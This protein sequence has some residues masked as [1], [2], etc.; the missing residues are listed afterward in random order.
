[1]T[2]KSTIYDKTFHRFEA[3][4]F[5]N[6]Q[7]DIYTMLDNKYG[8]Q[9]QIILQSTLTNYTTMLAMIISYAYQFKVI[10]SNVKERIFPTKSL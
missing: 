9:I 5:K 1:M 4:F 3:F 8:K 6:P 7:H 2:Q 10:I